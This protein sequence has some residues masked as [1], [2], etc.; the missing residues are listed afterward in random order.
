MPP[1]PK[2]FDTT[3]PIRSETG[4]LDKFLAARFPDHSRTYLQRLINGR[5]IT[6]DDHPVSPHHVLR[7]GQTVQI[8]WPKDESSSEEK[9]KGVLPFEILFEDES[10]LVLDKPAGLLSHPAGWK[11]DGSTLVELLRPWI[12]RKEWPDDVRPGLV[13]R[14]DRD[15]S[16][17]MVYAKT[18]E[19]HT[20]LSR[21]F[22][23]RQVKKTYIALVKGVPP[24]KTGTLEASLGRHPAK[25]QRFA[26]VDS[27][28]WSLTKFIVTENFGATASLL[29]LHPLTGRTHQLRVQLSAFG[30]PIL[31][32]RVYGMKDPAFAEIARHMLHARRLEFTHPKS[33]ERKMF[34]AQ[35][36]SDFQAAIKLIRSAQ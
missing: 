34:E 7:R 18:P 1:D 13:H 22:A 33:K 25:R 9:P 5:N 2:Q 14:L 23:S 24:S 36:P 15:T 26:V 28:R 3:F 16:G 12:S 6:V 11:R 31:G 27:G 20:A 32:D 10:L 30:F 21:Q 4:R 8:R 29:E 19:A 35:V 17:V